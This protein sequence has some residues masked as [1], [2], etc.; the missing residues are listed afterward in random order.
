MVA[1]RVLAYGDSL[2]AG[3]THGGH[4]FTPWAPLLCKLLGCTVCDHT[5]LSGW[6]TLQMV[7]ALDSQ[8]ELDVVDRQWPGLRHQ[9]RA[10]P[11][12]YDVVI[13]MSGTNDLAD[14]STAASI[15]ASVAKLH[16]AAHAEGAGSVVLPIPESN[17]YHHG[18]QP[19]SE[20]AWYAS[21]RDATNRALRQWAEAQPPELVAYV[22]AAAFVPFNPSTRRTLWEPDGLHMSPAGYEA[23]GTQ[24]APA[25]AAFVARRLALR[26]A[27]LPGAAVRIHSLKVAAEH[28]GKNGTLSSEARGDA[29]GEAHAG[30]WRER[31]ADAERLGV[32]LADGTH[33]SIKR[34]NLQLLG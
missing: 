31:L 34:A 7:E 21:L 16:E 6:R 13:I 5:G 11:A 9:M 25:V 14:R 30:R 17:I 3:Y 15:V 20:A 26:P 10:A 1:A 18:S 32:R 12:P 22:D 8:G 29:R 24:L 19:G 27:W 4:S 23:F 2:T 28:N 33:L